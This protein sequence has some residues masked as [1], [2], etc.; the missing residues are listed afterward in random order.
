MGKTDRSGLLWT[1]LFCTACGS[2]GQGSGNG[3]GGGG[4]TGG[5]AETL[6]LLSHDPAADALQ[7]AADAPVVLKFD[8]AVVAASLQEPETRLLRAGSADPVPGSWRQT[9]GGR[10]CIFTPQ[11]P[12]ALETDYRFELSPF[13][14]DPYGRILDATRSFAFRTLDTTP[15]VVRSASVAAN[16]VGVSRTDP[17]VIRF[18]GA[19]APA[20]ADPAHASLVD[21]LGN[22]HPLALRV[23]QDRLE[24]KPV[25]DLPGEQGFTLHLRR[26]G[27]A[28][29]AGN[30]LAETWKL[31]FTT[32]RDRTAPQVLACWPARSSG[33]SPR[34]QPVFTFD[35][36]IDPASLRDGSVLL[37]TGRGD[38]V[39]CSVAWS[40]DRRRMRV[41][42]AEPLEPGLSCQFELTAGPAALTDVSGNALATPQSLPLAIGLDDEAPRLLATVPAAGAARVSLDGD[43]VATFSEPLDPDSV[44]PDTVAL[45]GPD[46][47]VPAA[48][49][50]VAVDR[51]R[52]VPN[53]L[54][55]PGTTWRLHLT[56]GPDGLRDQAGNPLAQS[57]SIEF[58]TAND[59]TL[60]IVR[61]APLDGSLS[62]SPDAR[63][64]A[65]FDSE[66]DPATVTGDSVRLT[67]GS[68]P[69]PGTLR[70]TRG[71]RALEFV[72]EGGL[73]PSQTYVWTLRG[74]A[75]GLREVSG[76]G[77][78]ADVTTTF[79]VGY[80][81]D[82]T[83]PVVALTLNDIAPSRRG[84]L[85]VGPHGFTFDLHAY[86]PVHYAL[87]PTSLDLLLTGPGAPP[88]AERLFP[89]WRFE[90]NGRATLQLPP[91][92]L[93]APGPYEVS[94][95]V[96]DL[97]GNAG[98]SEPIAF[99]VVP[100]DGDVLPLERLQV[101][102]VRCDLDRDGNARTDFEDDLVRLGLLA[103]GDPI[104]T[105]GRLSAIVR[106]GIVAAAH[107]LY[108]RTPE[109]RPGSPDAIRIRLT[110]RRPLGVPHMQI[111]VGGPDPEGPRNRGFGA[112]STGI[113]G[114]AWYDYRNRSLTDVNVG[115]RPGLGV[116]PG[117][118]LLFQAKL[119][120]QVY[121]TYT[122]VWAKRFLPLAPDLN[123]TP[124]GR[125]ALDP[126]VLA[127]GF[128]YERATPEQRA[129]Y[130]VIF[131]AADDWAVAN[132]TI[133]AHEIGHSLG[134]VAPGP[135]PFG[136]HGDDSLHNEFSE[137]TDVMAPSVSYEAL[138]SI[139]YSF[140]DLTLAYLRHRI[141]LR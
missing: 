42:P 1:L 31:P 43:L 123:G 70:L 113:L 112:E 60:P 9:D 63:L 125:H 55:R 61:L 51:L 87:D 102:W 136:L 48:V 49:T 67:T 21:R 109:G 77:F 14:A 45:H 56:G 27:I 15:P 139:D 47:A 37:V 85:S 53:A 80:G 18:D 122:T 72:P 96:R 7:V 82:R 4:G 62:V 116:F 71:N 92:L 65:L 30:R 52:V 127:P 93:L 118:L 12:L 97:S 74:G 95:R 79:Q 101:V 132:G 134:L 89:H 100:F 68:V 58:T 119:H 76:N 59:A 39:P 98:S 11:H 24:L 16:A 64:T 57:Q 3:G 54:L 26:N 84:N 124:A 91:E 33:L 66:I 117:E 44:R 86:D 20:A 73:G 25:V 29:R 131:D 104:R 6:Q 83:A 138:V 94:A 35:E 34:I 50:L 8:A 108:G 126:V 19:L 106:D 46:G 5:S 128:D 137:I 130:R 75:A 13:T 114:R 121:P 107:A 133:L 38:T 111:T 141:L 105:N 110:T 90:A 78:A 17:I 2:G 69:V 140:R 135:N 41:L 23:D 103:H 81:P 32:A 88:D 115:V 120:L 22:P 40:E 28:D 129:R 99:R 36:S 10:T